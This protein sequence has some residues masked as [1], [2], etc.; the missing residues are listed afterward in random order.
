MKDLKDGHTSSLNEPFVRP[1]WPSL[2]AGGY[3]AFIESHGP[4][5]DHVRL[6]EAPFWT[7]SQ[8]GLL[9]EQVQEDADWVGIIDHLDCG[10]RRTTY[11]VR[12]QE[13][14]SH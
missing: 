7:A 9:R 1:A 12:S 11:E 3:E 8:S 5:A 13:I 14:S 6:S 2:W 4:L 10:L